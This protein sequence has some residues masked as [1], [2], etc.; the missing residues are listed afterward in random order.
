MNLVN[1]VKFTKANFVAFRITL[2]GL[3]L[4]EDRQLQHNRSMEELTLCLKYTYITT[5]DFV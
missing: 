2:R 5:L 3:A 4:K 1:R